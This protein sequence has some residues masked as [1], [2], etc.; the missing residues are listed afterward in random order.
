[1]AQEVRYILFQATEAEQALLEHLVPRDALVGPRITEHLRVTF[2]DTPRYGIGATVTGLLDAA[3]LHRVRRVDQ[4]ELLCALLA[5]CRRAHIP[6][7][8]R[9]TKGLELLGGSVALTVTLNAVAPDPKVTGNRVRYTDPD[10]HGIRP[11]AS[12]AASS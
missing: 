4:T 12:P 8:R 10:L 7:P 1:M 11:M 6:L 9:A 2:E 3:G 5:W